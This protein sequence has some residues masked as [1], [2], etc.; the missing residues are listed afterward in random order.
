MYIKNK[1]HLILHLIYAILTRSSFTSKNDF[2]SKKR[3]CEEKK[4]TW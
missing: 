3:R 1:C 2:V 4:K